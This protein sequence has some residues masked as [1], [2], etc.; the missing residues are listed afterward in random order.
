MYPREQGRRFVKEVTHDGPRG[1][2]GLECLKRIKYLDG[3][4]ILCY[5]S[6]NV[7]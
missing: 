7:K 6:A 1:S 2:W 5:G 3:I 4:S